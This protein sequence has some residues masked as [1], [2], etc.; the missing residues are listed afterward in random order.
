MILAGWIC[1]EITFRYFFDLI[2]IFVIRCFYEQIFY[3]IHNKNEN[4]TWPIF[5]GTK[6]VSMKTVVVQSTHHMGKTNTLHM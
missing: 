4:D 1:I 3:S 5:Q 2:C 6:P